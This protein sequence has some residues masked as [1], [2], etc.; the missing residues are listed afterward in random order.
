MIAGEAYRARHVAVVGYNFVDQTGGGAV[1]QINLQLYIDYVPVGSP[2]VVYGAP[3]STNP[4]EVGPIF[5]MG[6]DKYNIGAPGNPFNGKIDELRIS[7]AALTVDEFIKLDSAN[8]CEE[9]WAAGQGLKWDLNLIFF[10][11]NNL[12]LITSS[13]LSMGNRLMFECTLRDYGNITQIPGWK[14]RAPALA[15][16]K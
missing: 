15:I 1:D 7:A 10:E 5:N 16:E 9:L 12:S 4:G 6:T 8:T 3:S 13:G 2:F 11:T 14:Y